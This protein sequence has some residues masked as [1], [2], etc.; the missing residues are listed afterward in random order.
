MAKKIVTNEE[1]ENKMKGGIFNLTQERNDFLLPHIVEMI[2]NKEWLDIQPEYQRRRVWD[3][4]KKSVLIESILMNIPIP[5]IFLLEYDFSKYE[6]MDGQQRLDAI[7][8]FYNDD[9]QLSGLTFWSELNGLK[10][11]QLPKLVLRLLNRRRIS[12]TMIVTENFQDDIEI[13]KLRSLVFERLNTGGIKLSQQEI[14]NCLFFGKFNNLI[15][16]LASLE[17]F[18]NAW[19][20][21]N[22]K[23]NINGEII[24]EKLKSNSLFKRM[25]DC[26]IV[27]RFFG[28]YESKFVTG[29]SLKTI[30]DD[31]MDRHSDKII[32]VK[33]LNQLR[34]YFSNAL[35]LSIDVFGTDVFKLKDPL[36]GKQSKP[37]RNLYDAVMVVF[38]D[39][40]NEKDK[41]LAKKD[42][43]KLAV[44]E[45]F[46]KTE[47]Y[48]KLVGRKGS[49]SEI[50]SMKK[51]IK[52]TI[53]KSLK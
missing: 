5:P 2:G 1:I 23:E 17:N 48:D 25:A 37:L 19:G 3:Y 27:L 6:V 9:F 20:I 32:D 39:L 38:H 50:K 21:P 11:S 52:E 31:T 4:K 53:K 24:S 29:S 33:K 36:T 51:L 41:I 30:L 13:N 43:I 28:L 15:I 26:E 44:L 14:R 10:F 8:S 47:S 18:T 22:H 12:A 34:E 35:E 42:K 46:N 7:S 40:R 16:E 49:A 45:E